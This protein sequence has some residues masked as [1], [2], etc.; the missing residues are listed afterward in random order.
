MNTLPHRSQVIR[1]D[2]GGHVFAVT[3]VHPVK[4]GKGHA[5][6]QIALGPAFR[7]RVL[8]RKVIAAHADMEGLRVRRRADTKR[9]NRTQ[10]VPMWEPWR[11]HQNRAAL[12]YFGDDVSG[13]VTIE[14][15]SGLW[16]EL[17]TVVFDGL[18]QR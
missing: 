14:D 10:P 7:R 4:P 3:D 15:R 9:H 2:A 1:R 6:N 5:A 11:D 18:C 13:E 16:V 8:V 12:D 17:Q